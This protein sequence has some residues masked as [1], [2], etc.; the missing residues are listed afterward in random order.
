MIASGYM[1]ATAHHETADTGHA[2]SGPAPIC[3]ENGETYYGRG[4]V[5]LT[6]K[7]NYRKASDLLGLIGGR[8]LVAH[9]EMALDSLIATRMMFGGM[10]EGWFTGQEAGAI[11]Q[12]HRDG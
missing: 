1:L 10:G 11:F 6:W 4:F 8:D 7:E 3:K 2:P 5:Q 9:A 12:R